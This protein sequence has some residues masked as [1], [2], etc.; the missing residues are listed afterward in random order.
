MKTNSMKKLFA[1][2]ATLTTLA[3]AP[4]AQAAGKPSAPAATASADSKADR[5]SDI[6][7]DEAPSGA[8]NLNT[9]TEDELMLLP[10]VGASKA[11]AIIAWRKK[12]GGFKKVD[13]LTKVKGFGYKSL[14]KLK[15]YL[16]LSGPTTYHGKKG[17]VGGV[18]E[19]AAQP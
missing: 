8:V 9:A 15:P 19:S 3:L 16:T 12:Y 14:K 11:Q 13:D 10:G 18:S 2:L 6:S 1:L 7:K 5:A 17:G 4:V